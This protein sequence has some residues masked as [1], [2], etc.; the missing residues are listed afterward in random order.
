MAREPLYSDVDPDLRTDDQGNILILED[1]DAIN[2]SVENILGIEKG[3][4]VMDPSW[5]GSIEPYVARTANDS[6]AA[7]VRMAIS[8]SLDVDQ[9]IKVDRIT[10]EPLPDNA[11]FHVLLQY[12]LN[13][14]FIRGEFERIISAG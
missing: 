9:R 13:A 10:V 4:L 12:G 1:L 14:A 2:A 11:A 8:D 7:F 3:E 5:G 6:S